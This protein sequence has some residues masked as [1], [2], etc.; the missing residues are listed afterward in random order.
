M[1]AADTC[2]FGKWYDSPAADPF[3]KLPGFKTVRAPH[4]A[5]HAAAHAALHAFANRDQDAA[6]TAFAQMEKATQDVLAALKQL[7]EEARD[8]HPDAA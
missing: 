1:G 7:A 3:R 6:E 5:Q 4:E 8:I 2:R